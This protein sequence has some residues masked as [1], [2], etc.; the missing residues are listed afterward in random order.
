MTRTTQRVVAA[1]AAG[2]TTL[3]LFTAVAS[4]ADSDQAAKL[5]ARIKPMEMVAKSS[6]E[7]RR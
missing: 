4:L 6:A 1:V 7:A 5:A 3:A 2:V